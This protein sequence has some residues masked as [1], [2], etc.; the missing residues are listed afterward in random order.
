MDPSF[1]ELGYLDPH[2]SRAMD[3]G[4]DDSSS[5]GAATPLPARPTSATSNR[6]KAV[7]QGRALRDLQDYTSRYTGSSQEP[8]RMQSPTSDS[9]IL[10]QV[11]STSKRPLETEA[12]GMISLIFTALML[13][14][15]LFSPEHA[16]TKEVGNI[17]DPRK[18]SCRKGT[19][20]ESRIHFSRFFEENLQVQRIA[21]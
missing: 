13:I 3:I 1:Y 15:C 5:Q 10:L 14:Y 4:D 9:N 20:L 2:T 19:S 6:G 11:A 17:R 12:D 21:L 16:K 8:S 18:T 7:H